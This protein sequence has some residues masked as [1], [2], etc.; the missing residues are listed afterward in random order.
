[1]V[2]K[3][4]GIK[5]ICK[6]NQWVGWQNSTTSLTVM[7]HPAKSCVSRAACTLLTH[8]TMSEDG[9]SDAFPF[10]ELRGVR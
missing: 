3:A 5:R 9:H 7:Y 1:M 10:R 2:R 4:K 8:A 6:L